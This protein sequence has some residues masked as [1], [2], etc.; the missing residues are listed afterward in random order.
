MPSSGSPDCLRERVRPATTRNIRALK[1]TGLPVLSAPYGFHRDGLP[2][3]LR[4]VGP[5][6][7][8]KQILRIGHAYAQATGWHLRVP[9]KARDRSSGKD[10]GGPAIL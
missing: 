5:A 7:G 2:I 10:P 1:L 4:V 3:G 9:A 6:F 8:E